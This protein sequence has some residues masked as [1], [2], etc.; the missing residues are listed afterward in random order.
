[1]RRFENWQTRMDQ[2]VR[3]HRAQVHEYGI[4]DCALMAAS[5]LDNVTGSE[6]Y[7]THQGHYD[8]AET[9]AEYLASLGLDGLKG[10]ASSILGSPLPN[11]KFRHRGDIALFDTRLGPALGVVALSGLH[12]LGLNPDGPGFCAVPLAEASAIWRV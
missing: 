7:V 9:A 12:I 3:F 1:M 5:H 2:W 10:L 11:P 4:W 6:L 8:S